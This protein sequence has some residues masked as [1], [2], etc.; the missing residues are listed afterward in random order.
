MKI[1]DAA[2]TL[3][4][5]AIVVGFVAL[6]ATAIVVFDGSP[7]VE[8]GTAGPFTHAFSFVALLAA[9]FV[10]VRTDTFVARRGAAELPTSVLP[11]PGLV[12]EG[13]GAAP[14]TAVFPDHQGGA[15]SH[16]TRVVYWDDAGVAGV[17][18]VAG[19]QARLHAGRASAVVHYRAFRPG[20]TA[21][22]PVQTL[23]IR[24]GA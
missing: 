6:V 21:M 16:G 8:G 24:N 18:D 10:A 11:P 22:G 9:A 23:P 20:S 7:F 1:D 15:S 17:A 4:C 13:A 12:S 19:R 3:A 2:V 5:R 14:V